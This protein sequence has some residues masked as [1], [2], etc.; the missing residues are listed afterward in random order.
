MQ[1]KITLYG[2][3]LSYFTGKVLCYLRYKG[4]PFI[5][6]PVNAYTL[7]RRIKK[8]TGEMVMP[9]ITLPDGEWIQDSTIII[10]RL[11]AQFP[12]RPVTPTTPVQQFAAS[13]M[14][15]WGDEW[16]VPI[17][18]HT[19][20]SYSENY[21]LFEH[22][23]GRALLPYFPAFLQRRIVAR[24]ANKLRGMLHSVGVRP[25]Q[26]ALMNQWTEDML[27]LFETHFQQHDFLFGG[28]PCIGDFGLVGTMYGHLGRDPWP[29]RELI[30]PRPALQAWLHRMSHP[31]AVS[32][33]ALLE[34]DRIAPT[35]APVFKAIFHEFLPMLEGINQQIKA[36]LPT[37]P[38]GK[39]LARVMADVASPMGSG[40]FSRCGLPY[41]LWMA[42]RT[43]DLYHAMSAQEQ[44]AVKDWLKEVGG[45]AFLTLDI[46]RLRRSGLRVVPVGQAV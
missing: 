17:A 43:L 27:D 3:H 44:E 7:M 31:D 42:Q 13:L 10:E 32:A 5:D 24:V 46:P 36:A 35:L 9:V 4:I 45:M 15:A 39:A 14:E 37:L 28:H 23:A 18:M 2:W 19:R 30:A 11:E 16:W 34:N 29:A 12:H 38:A 22:D 8:E 26:F 33:P 41:T 40:T 25:A 6:Q 1:K 20:W 21:A